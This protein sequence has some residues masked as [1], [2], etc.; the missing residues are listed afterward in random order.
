M[1]E[2][3]AFRRILDKDFP[4]FGIYPRSSKGI[5]YDLFVENNL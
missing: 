3:V 5:V 4:A 2:C 1:E